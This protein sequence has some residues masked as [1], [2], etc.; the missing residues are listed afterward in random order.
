MVPQSNMPSSAPAKTEFAER[1]ALVSNCLQSIEATCNNSDKSLNLAEKTSLQRAK[2]Q[3]E[4]LELNNRA[5]D[6]DPLASLSAEDE[7]FSLKFLEVFTSEAFSQDLDMLRQTEGENMSDSDFSTLADSIKSL[8]LGM[9]P[10]NRK[11][12]NRYLESR[13]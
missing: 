6:V 11:L 1:L 12:F 13:S 5:K 8:G 2:Q 4:K 7:E 9:T 10:E 3:L